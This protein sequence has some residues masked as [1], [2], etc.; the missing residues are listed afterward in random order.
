[1]EPPTDREFVDALRRVANLALWCC[2]AGEPEL[3]FELER[4]DESTD[5]LGSV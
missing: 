3:T 1:V 4:T 2:L 5:Q